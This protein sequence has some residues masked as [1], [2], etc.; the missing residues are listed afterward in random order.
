MEGLT[1]LIWSCPYTPHSGRL[2]APAR[3]AP[4][5]PAALA[6]GD[7]CRVRVSYSGKVDERFCYLDIETERY[8]SQ[9]RM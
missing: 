1:A 3:R 5:A 4:T 7:T 2:F 9:Y 8:E 6:P